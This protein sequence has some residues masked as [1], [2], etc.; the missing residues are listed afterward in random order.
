MMYR[1]MVKLFVCTVAQYAY[2]NVRA[3]CRILNKCKFSNTKFF[4]IA[5][6]FQCILLS[7]AS[8]IGVA[9]EVISLF[10]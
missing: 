4:E 3:L 7:M 1:D 5:L 9:N 2:Y 6:C 10:R 8:C